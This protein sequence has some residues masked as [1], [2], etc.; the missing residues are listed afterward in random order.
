VNNQ[1][2]VITLE[3]GQLKKSIVVVYEATH[4]YNSDVDVNLLRLN[5]VYRNNGG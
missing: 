4:N 2:E 1:R 3:E 5:I